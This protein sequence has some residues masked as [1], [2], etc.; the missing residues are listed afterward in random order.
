L[1]SGFLLET[2]L[3]KESIMQAVICRSFDGPEAL[4]I[5]HFTD[6]VPGPGEIL[7]E[8]HAASVSFMDALMVSGRYQMRPETPFVSGSDAVGVVADLGPGVTRFRRGDRVACT[9]FVGAHGEKMVVGEWQAVRIPDV[10]PFEQAATLLYAYGTAYYSLVE[11]A[12]LR[13]GE[14]LFVTGAAGGVGLAAVDLGRHLGA[15]VIAGIGSDE[16]AALVQA[17]GAAETINYGTESVKDRIK[18]ST[19][20]KGVDVCVEI[21]GG[22]V[23]E[24]MTR[25]MAWGGRLLP[26]GFTSG[27]IPSVPMNLPLLKNYSIVGVFYGASM[28]HDPR[29][30]VAMYETIMRLVAAGD[31]RPCVHRVVPLGEAREA[32]R[33]IV[34]RSVQ[35]RIVLKL[36]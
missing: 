10:V 35:G 8:V 9:S 27:T 30:T 1:A 15:R 11:R 2:K 17:Y 32:M 22:A 7:V 29:S 14:S 13:K 26:I 31:L 34:D 19:R 21:L 24:Q 16:K 25:L 18:E 3:G 36:R 20:G 12:Q 28:Q 6:P 23:F 5:G 4:E 33:A